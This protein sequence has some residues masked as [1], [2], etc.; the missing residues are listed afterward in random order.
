M[1]YQLELLRSQKKKVTDIFKE[2][3]NRGAWYAPHPELILQ[4]MLC[5]EDE[6]ERRFAVNKICSLRGPGDEST[7]IGNSCVRNRK[8]PTI[9]FNSKKLADLIEWTSGVTEPPLTLTLMTMELRQLVK[10]VTEAAAHV[11]TQ[12]RRDGYIRSQ[13]AS[14]ELM[15]RN[16][17]KQDLL[18]FVK[19]RKPGT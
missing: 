17:R 8:T 2:T 13:Q 1:L 18:K 3:L 6:Q 12:E 14:A 16:R 9:N 7:Q 11:Y 4:T 15:S 10:R 5:S 19:F